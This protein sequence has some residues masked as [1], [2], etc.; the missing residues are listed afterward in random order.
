MA[1][2]KY[3]GAFFRVLAGGGFWLFVWGGIAAFFLAVT[4]PNIER[5]SALEAANADTR[6][7]I[8]EEEAR[9]ERIREMGEYSE[10]DTFIEAAAR[11]Y[12]GYIFPDEIVFIKRK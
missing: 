2:I 12:L 10:T 1:L 4:Y 7:R 6:S 11:K 5:L 3:I 9:M 8:A